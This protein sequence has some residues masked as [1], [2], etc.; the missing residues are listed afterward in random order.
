VGYRNFVFLDPESQTQLNPD[1]DPKHCFSD[2]TA[3][4]YGRTLLNYFNRSHVTLRGLRFA[5]IQTTARVTCIKL[6]LSRVSS[7]SRLEILKI[8]FIIHS[9]A[10]RSH[11]SDHMS[12]ARK[13]KGYRIRS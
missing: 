3:E 2:I 11:D 10:Q 7:K 5:K 1:Q 4:Y 8:F 9:L 6:C 13:H 12:P